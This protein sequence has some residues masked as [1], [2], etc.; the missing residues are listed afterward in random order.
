MEKK[1]HNLE[2]LIKHS[3][4][5][6]DFTRCSY[7]L[8]NLEPICIIKYSKWN[9]HILETHYTTIKDF[10]NYIEPNGEFYCEAF[11]GIIATHQTKQVF[12]EFK[13]YNLDV[14]FELERFNDEGFSELRKLYETTKEVAAKEPISYRVDLNGWKNKLGHQRSLAI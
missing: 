3:K 10:S 9:K 12:F 6:V 13:D 5:L 4:N 8:S 7:E 2:Q 14:K 1:M 11:F